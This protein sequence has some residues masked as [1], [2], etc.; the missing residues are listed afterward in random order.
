[1]DS[2]ELGAMIAQPRSPSGRAPRLVKR[3]ARSATKSPT[4]TLNFNPVTALV[5]ILSNSGWCQ[6]LR[7]SLHR[8][9]TF[10]PSRMRC[11]LSLIDCCA[12]H[13][14]PAWGCHHC[15]SWAEH[16]DRGLCVFNPRLAPRPNSSESVTSLSESSN[17]TLVL[18]QRA[19]PADFQRLKSIAPL[20]SAKLKAALKSPGQLQMISRL[21]ILDL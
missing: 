2:R 10:S 16:N 8:M 5:L 14:F 4:P 13:C 20:L 7:R 12:R 19:D 18:S 17:R 6:Q 15:S 3:I 1:M 21:S 9:R 11:S